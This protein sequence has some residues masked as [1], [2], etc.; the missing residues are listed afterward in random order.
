MEYGCS[1]MLPNFYECHEVYL[2][3][4]IVNSINLTVNWKEKQ[5]VAKQYKYNW[6]FPI[7]KDHV[8]INTHR[9]PTKGI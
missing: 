4:D 2:P 8:C 3:S 5:Q 9:K 7:F 6:L 1:R